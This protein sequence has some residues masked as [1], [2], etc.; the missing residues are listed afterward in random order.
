MPYL[1]N[2]GMLNR[3]ISI[4]VM[5]CAV[6]LHSPF[7]RIISKI[8]EYSTSIMSTANEKKMTENLLI[9]SSLSP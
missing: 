5:F 9:Y 4:L 2:T 8:P 7:H 6:I 1:R 3:S